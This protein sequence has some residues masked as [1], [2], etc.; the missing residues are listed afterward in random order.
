MDLGVEEMGSCNKNSMVSLD[1]HERGLKSG[2]FIN[3]YDNQRNENKAPY[4][5]EKKSLLFYPF[6]VSKQ[7]PCVFTLLTLLSMSHDLIFSTMWYV[8]PTKPQI[9]LRIRAV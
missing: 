8:R 3:G 5:H 1:P 7:K 9:S 2:K 6:S 4:R